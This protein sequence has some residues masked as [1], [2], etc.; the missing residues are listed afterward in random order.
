MKQLFNDT[1]DLTKK[2][3]GLS[4]E[5]TLNKTGSF[6]QIIFEQ[7][8]TAEVQYIHSNTW[9]VLPRCSGQTEFPVLPFLWQRIHIQ[10]RRSQNCPIKSQPEYNSPIAPNKN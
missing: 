3:M 7:G 6:I 4:F 5:I 1:Y 8:K 10:I 2:L 9:L